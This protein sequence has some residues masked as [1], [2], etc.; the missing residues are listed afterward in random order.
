MKKCSKITVKDSETLLTYSWIQ[1]EIFYILYFNLSR[2]AFFQLC[3]MF[4]FALG[5]AIVG[6]N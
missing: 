5:N 2:I 4:S 6:K 3:R 1:D